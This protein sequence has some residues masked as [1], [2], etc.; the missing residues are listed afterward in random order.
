MG[1]RRNVLASTPGRCRI[2]YRG[3]FM[4]LYG[5]HCEGRFAKGVVDKTRAKTQMFV[6]TTQMKGLPCL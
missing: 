2:L 1:R 4:M 5:N 6:T 3:K